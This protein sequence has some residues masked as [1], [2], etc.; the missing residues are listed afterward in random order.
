MCQHTEYTAK[1]H[2]DKQKMFQKLKFLDWVIG[3]A[4]DKWEKMAAYYRG[5]QIMCKVSVKSK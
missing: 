5:Y 4:T 1:K 3:A 2:M